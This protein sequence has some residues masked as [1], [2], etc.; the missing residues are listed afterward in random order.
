MFDA[1]QNQPTRHWRNFILHSLIASLIVPI[2]GLGK[3]W[4]TPFV[5]VI[6]GIC[7]TQLL[8]DRAAIFAVAPTFLLFALAAIEPILCPG[9]ADGPI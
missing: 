8:K 1:I 2:A 6:I 9:I 3:Y 7:A 4:L 5:G